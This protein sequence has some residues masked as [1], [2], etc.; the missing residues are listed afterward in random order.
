MPLF[1]SKESKQSETK[2]E[3]PEPPKISPRQR[4]M[5]FFNTP[6]I[7][8]RMSVVGEKE[9]KGPV[10]KY[11]QKCETDDKMGEKL[12]SVR[13]FACLTPPYAARCAMLARK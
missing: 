11:F 5:R 12:S 2:F 10:G 13:K 1:K 4:V 6:R 9:S 8:G 3:F 7:V